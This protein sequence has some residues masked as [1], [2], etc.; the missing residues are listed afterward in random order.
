MKRLNKINEILIYVFIMNP[1]LIVCG[2]LLPLLIMVSLI[3]YLGIVLPNI[4][5]LCLILLFY[6]IKIKFFKNNFKLM[7]YQICGLFVGYVW[8]ILLIITISIFR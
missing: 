5:T 2:A 3:K 6:I 8:F 7:F 4:I 1:L